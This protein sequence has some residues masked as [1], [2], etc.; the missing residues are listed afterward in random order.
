MNDRR[1]IARKKLEPF[2]PFFLL[3]LCKEKQTRWKWACGEWVQSPWKRGYYLSLVCDGLYPG[4]R[5]LVLK[6]KA[7]RGIEKA[8][9]HCRRRKEEGKCQCFSFLKSWQK[10]SRTNPSNS[11]WWHRV[12]EW[13]GKKAQKN[14]YWLPEWK[15]TQGNEAWLPFTN[16][17]YIWSI[18][19]EKGRGKSS[20]YK[21]N[22]TNGCISKKTL[23]SKD[24][25]N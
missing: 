6:Y 22:K 7:I 25:N 10:Q 23:Q 13:Q 24:S 14:K 20:V 19:K 1:E 15:Q 16:I 21:S 5:A 11:L 18:L 3:Q 17:Q 9:G 12:G 4:N 8:A 2:S